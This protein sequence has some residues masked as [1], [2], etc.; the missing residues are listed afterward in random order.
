MDRISLM[1]RNVVIT[2]RKMSSRW[3]NRQV[4]GMIH[5]GNGKLMNRI[6]HRH[7]RNT[8]FYILV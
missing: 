6:S 8:S 3:T 2:K 4:L 1:E 7:M 5:C